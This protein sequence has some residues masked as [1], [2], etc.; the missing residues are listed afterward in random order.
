MRDDWHTSQN[1]LRKKTVQTLSMFL[2][3]VD[4]SEYSWQENTWSPLIKL[5][6]VCVQLLTLISASSC[7][8]SFDNRSY[9]TGWWGWRSNRTPPRS[10]SRGSRTLWTGCSP[11]AG[12]TAE[13]V[14]G[15]AD[16]EKLWS[17]YFTNI[18]NVESHRAGGH[19]PAAERWGIASTTGTS[20]CE[21]R[22][23]PGRS[24]NTSQCEQ[25]CWW[26]QWRM[27]QGTNRGM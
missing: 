1:H 18:C 9:W 11:C 5:R 15:E 22:W 26:G 6:C 14:P 12:G 17:A 10:W 8:G 4:P 3:L 7:W 24:K 19:S 13:T 20:A 2:P 16:R 21:G 25:R 23:R 27:L